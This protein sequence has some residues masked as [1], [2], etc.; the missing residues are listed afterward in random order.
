MALL[1]LSSSSGFS[2]DFHYCQGKLKSFSLLGDA[3]NCH[4][5][6]ASNKTCK[7]H[8]K[9]LE[10]AET[11]CEEKEDCCKNDKIHF[12]LEQ[13]QI[14]STSDSGITNS[15]LTYSLAYSASLRASFDLPNDNYTPVYYK[16]P[17][18]PKDIPVLIQS[19]LL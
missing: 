5:K 4:D 19:F 8:Q 1:L 16:P 18:I 13:D 6:L 7:H 9:N 2:I 10:E 11:S 3:K 14:I 17:L 12:Q 15:G